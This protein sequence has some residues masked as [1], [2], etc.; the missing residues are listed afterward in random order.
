M[1]EII[2]DNTP[3]NASYG[4][5]RLEVLDF[6]SSD[7]LEMFNKDAFGLYAINVKVSQADVATA[8]EKFAMKADVSFKER[9]T[10]GRDVFR[11]EEVTK[12]RSETVPMAFW[13]PTKM[14]TNLTF[15][16]NLEV[17]PMR[18]IG[19]MIGKTPTHFKSSYLECLGYYK[20]NRAAGDEADL[21]AMLDDR[22]VD[23]VATGDP[24]ETDMFTGELY[25]SV[26]SPGLCVAADLKGVLALREQGIEASGATVTK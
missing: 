8:L 9:K 25:E 10:I 11:M 17:N 23:C 26:S 20:T 14:G 12:L 15:M 7:Q 2:N 18:V 13:K 5:K 4:P 16:C 24:I 1:N 3:K 21:F 19:Q 22:E 6:V